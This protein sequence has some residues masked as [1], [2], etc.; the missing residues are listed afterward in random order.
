MKITDVLNVQTNS[1]LKLDFQINGGKNG[2]SG[3]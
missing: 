3:Q 2:E 1:C